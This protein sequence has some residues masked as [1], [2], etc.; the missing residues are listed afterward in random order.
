M[1]A[2]ADSLDQRAAE[3][4]TRQS[5]EQSLSEREIAA[6]DHWR[7]RETHPAY[8]ARQ[9]ALVEIEELRKVSPLNW[10]I[11]IAIVVFVS[12]ISYFFPEYKWGITVFLL[13]FL[14]DAI[15]RRVNKQIL[16]A[17]YQQVVREWEV[18]RYLL[19][20][21]EKLDGTRDR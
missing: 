12:V 17:Q 7:N 2:A 5:Q 16:I 14:A 3:L 6:V 8:L 18:H 19:F 10:I 9:N 13:I 20:L 11:G 21:A 4:I 15:A 1:A